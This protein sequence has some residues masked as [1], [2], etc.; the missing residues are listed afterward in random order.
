MSSEPGGGRAGRTSRRI[1]ALLFF[2]S[3]AAGLV[4]QVAWLRYLS[5]VFGNTTLAT[6]TLL[7]VFMAGLG[8]G[9]F[10]FGRLSDRTPRPLTVYALLEVAIGL[11]AIFS[12][13]FFDGMTAAYVEVERAVGGASGAPWSFALLRIGLAALCLLPPTLL[14]GGTLPL[15]VRGLR[16]ARGPVGEAANASRPARDTAL[17]YGANTLG[18]V[19][20]VAGAGF[21]TIP[22]FG[23]HASL[24]LSAGLNFAAALGAIA[25][26]RRHS[27]TPE[28]APVPVEVED[29]PATL[30]SRALA[31]AVDVGLLA[32][33]DLVVIYFT[34]KICRLPLS[35]IAL[36]PK[37]PLVAFLILQNVGYLIAFTASGQ[38]LGKMI[39]GVRVLSNDTDD[40]PDVASAAMRAAVWVVLAL[41]AGLGL[42]TAGLS[43]DG[44]GLHDRFAGTRVVRAGA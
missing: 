11:F 35:D 33:I 10:L 9:A 17:L 37:A 30:G 28:P 14:M 29:E 38:T 31:S 25:L 5:L 2:A 32:L 19:C 42:L 43:R 40:T 8:L 20:G 22:L 41:P 24:L 34:M 36:L 18:A 3:G 15:I 23:L 44:R 39:A 13:R 27:A 12:P 16:N 6:A 1:L 4:D 26:S 21:L 7:A